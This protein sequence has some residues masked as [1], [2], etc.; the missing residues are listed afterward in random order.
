L[1]V[2]KIA[3]QIMRMCSVAGANQRESICLAYKHAGS[4]GRAF[5]HYGDSAQTSHQAEAANP[6][7]RISPNPVRLRP[8]GFGL[9]AFVPFAG[10]SWHGLAQ[11]ELAKRASL[12]VRIIRKN[13]KFSDEPSSAF[14]RSESAWRKPCWVWRTK[15]SATM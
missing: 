1:S 10:S 5:R 15:T 11:P 3:P 4:F 13:E 14:S 6:R 9:T 12:S 8:A 7:Q 2:G